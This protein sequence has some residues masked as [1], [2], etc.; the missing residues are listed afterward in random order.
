L[1]AFAT[2]EVGALRRTVFVGGVPVWPLTQEV[3]CLKVGVIELPASRLLLTIL[4]LAIIRTARRAAG[5]SSAGGVEKVVWL[6]TLYA[7]LPIKVWLV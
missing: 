1:D 7:L 4:F 2:V 3:R 5:A 6:V